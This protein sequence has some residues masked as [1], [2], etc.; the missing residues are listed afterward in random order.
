SDDD[1]CDLRQLGPCDLTDDIDDALPDLG[2]GGVH[3]RDEV[4][5]GIGVKADAGRAVV[6]EPLRIADVLVAER[7]ADSAPDAVA[8]RRVPGASGEAYRIARELLG[9]RLRDRGA[10][11]QD[12]FHRQRAFDPLS[13][14]KRVALPNGVLDAE[15]D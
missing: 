7:E 4:A 15:L 3:L 14:R 9:V 11:A 6:V 12:L 2:R 10:A 8:A 5:A 1:V 13:G